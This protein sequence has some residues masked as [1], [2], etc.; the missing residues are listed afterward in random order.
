MGQRFINKTR[1]FIILYL[2]IYTQYV[3]LNLSDGA[4]FVDSN[5]D[6]FS[7]ILDYLRYKTVIIPPAVPPEALQVGGVKVHLSSSDLKIK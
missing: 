5:P 1:N 6:V 3:K 4:F 7:V 2:V